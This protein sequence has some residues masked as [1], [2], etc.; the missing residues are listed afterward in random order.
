MNIR[1]RMLA[2]AALVAAAAGCGD[3]LREGQSPVILVVDSLQGT[4]GA[5]DETGNPLL[6]DVITLVR[7]PAPCAPATP[8]P[9]VFNDLGSATL[10]L[11]PKD[12]TVTPT[13]NN[14]VTIR[15]Y[16]VRFR[17]NDGRNVPGV[18]VPHPFDGALTLTVGPGANSIA[19]FELVRHVAKKESPLIQ[20]VSNS[21][22]ITTIADITFYGSDLVGNEVTATGSM[23]VEFGNFGDF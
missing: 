18:D 15:R 11:V 17:R 19:G 8:C 9:T 23:V 1:I 4:S 13:S 12:I 5:T 10:S 16:T 3:V 20:L 21:A 22:I 2:L 6:S 7:A 14:Q